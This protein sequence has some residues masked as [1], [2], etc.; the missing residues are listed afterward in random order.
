MKLPL[1]FRNYLS[2]DLFHQHFP[3]YQHKG[4]LIRD[5]TLFVSN[6]M[7]NAVRGNSPLQLLMW[8]KWSFLRKSGRQKWLCNIFTKIPDSLHDIYLPQPSSSIS[9][10][11]AGTW[12]MIKLLFTIHKNYREWPKANGLNE[13]CGSE[14]Q[15]LG[16]FYVKTDINPWKWLLLK[17]SSGKEKKSEKFTV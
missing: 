12:P 3:I 6:H 5:I 14:Q 15:A 10:K 17:T 11:R 8:L 9:L 4:K 2:Q 7:V 13:N 16:N 1:Y